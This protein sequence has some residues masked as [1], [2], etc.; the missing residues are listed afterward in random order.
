[1]PGLDLLFGTVEKYEHPNII[2]YLSVRLP[3]LALK[4]LCG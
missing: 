4:E 3:Y 1:M 2:A